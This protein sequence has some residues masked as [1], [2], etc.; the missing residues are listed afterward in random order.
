MNEKMNEPPTGSGAAAYSAGAL[1]LGC[2]LNKRMNK[3]TN[4]WM[5]E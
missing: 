2:Y 4:E 3:W 1:Y 5:N